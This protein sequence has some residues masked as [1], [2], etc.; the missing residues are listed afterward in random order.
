MPILTLPPLHNESSVLVPQQRSGMFSFG[1]GGL[2]V[3][4]PTFRARPILVPVIHAAS[5]L[6]P[7]GLSCVDAVQVK[8]TGE[9]LIQIR[10]HALPI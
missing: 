7:F 1:K 10:Y 6:S 8:S 5:T 2:A 3:E 4:R 9:N